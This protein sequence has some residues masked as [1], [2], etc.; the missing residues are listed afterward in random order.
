MKQFL[1]QKNS[2]VISRLNIANTLAALVYFILLFLVHFCLLDI[3]YD[4]HAKDRGR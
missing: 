1:H 4:P 2:V 3:F